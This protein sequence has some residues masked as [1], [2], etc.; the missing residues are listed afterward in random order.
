MDL[1]GEF[2][3]EAP[4]SWTFF[5]EDS[6]FEIENYFLNVQIYEEA[7]RLAGFREIR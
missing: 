3:E 5:L 1:A 6:S 4:I 2:R 7:F